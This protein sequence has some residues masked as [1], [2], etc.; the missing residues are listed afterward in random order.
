MNKIF[1]FFQW[2]WDLLPT[3]QCVMCSQWFPKKKTKLHL[4]STGSMIPVCKECWTKYTG[5][6]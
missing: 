1:A 5:E 3:V 4:I 2:L 6:K